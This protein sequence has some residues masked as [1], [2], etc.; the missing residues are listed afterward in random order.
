MA[1]K[2]ALE[3]LESKRLLA[4]TVQ[5]D[6]KLGQLNI[7]G[8]TD[9]DVVLVQQLKKSVEVVAN[10][11]KHS[12]D[13]KA[14]SAI[15]FDGGEG[16]DQFT[17]QSD[18][19]AVAYGNSG[20]DLLI[21]GSSSDDLRGGPDHDKLVG[22]DGDDQLH[23]DYGDDHL[24]GGKGNDDLRGWYG[25]DHIWG[26][27]GHDRLSGYEG[28]DRIWGG[29][30]DD[31][32]KGHE[33]NDELFGEDGND[34]LLGW[35][36]DDS[37]LGGKGNDYLSGWAGQDVLV[38]GDGDDQLRGHAGRDLLIGGKGSDVLEGGS[39]VDILIGG[40]SH[41]DDNLPVLRALLTAWN[42]NPKPFG[43]DFSPIIGHKHDKLGPFGILHDNKTDHFVDYDPT[44][45]WLVLD[46]NGLHG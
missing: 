37:L 41:V 36:G 39:S 27:D 25:N 45:D 22:N 34:E 31:A 4:V 24:V 13:A 14:V 1:R 19:P 38:G 46:K 10:G 20:N 28:N 29:G 21:G 35:T 3:C 42:A 26:D 15:R 44:Q 11:Q 23:G 30:G 32:L 9:A 6:T 12:F 16:N 43:P 33:G 5:L 8:G 40:W 2:L 18:L 17:N 7:K